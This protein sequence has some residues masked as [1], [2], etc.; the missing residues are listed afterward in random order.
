M[1]GEEM[2]D[3]FELSKEEL[4]SPMSDEEIETLEQAVPA[5]RA[6]GTALHL[7]WRREV[8]AGRSPNEDVS[9]GEPAWQVASAIVHAVH[10]LR[11]AGGDV[12]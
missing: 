6:I 12:K 2:M 11:K 10:L 9:P 7:T 3:Q 5:A 1:T 8:E 4:D